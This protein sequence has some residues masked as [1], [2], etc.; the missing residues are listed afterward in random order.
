[1]FNLRGIHGKQLTTRL[2]TFKTKCNVGII[3]LLKSQSEDFSAGIENDDFSLW[4]CH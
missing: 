3:Q 2:I 4:V 1:M